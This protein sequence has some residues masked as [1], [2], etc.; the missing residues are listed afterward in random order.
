MWIRFEH[1]QQQYQVGIEYHKPTIL[2]KIMYGNI[3]K[4]YY[5]H[6]QRVSDKETI[7]RVKFIK[8]E[9]YTLE[10]DNYCLIT[11]NELLDCDIEDYTNCLI[12]IAKKMMQKYKIID[13]KN[14]I[15]TDRI[16]RV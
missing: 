9:Q 16:M 14:Q 4:S 11:L 1:K 12:E 10:R 2:E 13:T 7:L 5:L 8:Y 3:Q 6:I 15:F